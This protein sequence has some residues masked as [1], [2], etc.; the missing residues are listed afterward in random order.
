MEIQAK[1]SNRANK[2]KR[3][4]IPTWPPSY[5][6]SKKTQLKELQSFTTEQMPGLTNNASIRLLTSLKQTPGFRGGIA[7]IQELW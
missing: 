5:C 1:G 7:S 6:K 2:Q 4:T 3:K